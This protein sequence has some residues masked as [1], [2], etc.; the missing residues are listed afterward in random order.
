MF[1]FEKLDIYK[2]AVS[3]AK[4]IYKITRK[5]PKEELFGISSQLRRAALSVSLNISEGSSRGKKEFKHFLSIAIGSVYE[6]IPL[7]DISKEENY[8][9]AEE[10]KAIYMNCNKIAAMLNALKNSIK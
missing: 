10:N 9:S 8:I 1:N 2:E 7:I 6:C 4:R 5:F 3:F